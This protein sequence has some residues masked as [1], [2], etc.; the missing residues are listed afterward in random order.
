[1][2]PSLLQNIGDPLFEP[3]KGA[4][5]LRAW[6]RMNMENCFVQY[7]MDSSDYLF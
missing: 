5:R 6:S 4:A 7:Q 1:M 2:T 3:G